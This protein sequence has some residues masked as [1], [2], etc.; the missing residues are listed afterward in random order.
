M[1]LLS[2]KRIGQSGYELALA[3]FFSFFIHAAIVAAALFLYMA[4]APKKYVPPFYNVKLVGLPADIAPTPVPQTAP[5]PPP[6]ET[7]KTKTAEKPKAEKA[8]PK[9][10]RSSSKAAKATSKKGAMAELNQKRTKPHELEQAEQA[11]APTTTAPGK[12]GATVEG[13][14]VSSSSED[15]KFQFYMASISDQINRNW[16]PPPGAQGMK[17]KVQFT[18]NHSGMLSGYPNL[19][20]SSGNFY[21]DQAA[22]RT[23]QQ[24]NPFP[25]MP[26]E[27]YKQTA[28]FSV[29]LMLKE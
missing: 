11:T 27:F 1:K 13:V 8:Q 20:E 26:E 3:V 22:V 23:I 6:L 29:D 19:I 24:S 5:L 12:A 4:A 10:K 9:S 21:F 18:I 15:F 16:N 17:A 2:G 7:P 28:T 25:P 14:S